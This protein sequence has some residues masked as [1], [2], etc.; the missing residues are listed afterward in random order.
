MHWSVQVQVPDFFLSLDGIYWITLTH[1]LHTLYI[2]PFENSDFS[3]CHYCT[4]VYYLLL[5]SRILTMRLDYDLLAA[6]FLHFA[7]LHHENESNEATIVS[8]PHPKNTYH[9]LLFSL[10]IFMSSRCLFSV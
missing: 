8:C 9:F 2:L 7:F 1:I 10:S 3:D 5:Y 6:H 4:A